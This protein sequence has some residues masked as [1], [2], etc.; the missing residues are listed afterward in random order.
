MIIMAQK[1]K[2]LLP[3]RSHIDVVLL[4]HE[5]NL[6]RVQPRESEHSNLLNNMAPITRCA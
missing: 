6:L 1:D 3:I 2:N 4:R 5:S